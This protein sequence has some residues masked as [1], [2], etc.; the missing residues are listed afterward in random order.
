MKGAIISLFVLCALILVVIINGVFVTTTVK[1]IETDIQSISLEEYG[2]EDALL[3]VERAKEI[4]KSKSTLLCLSLK[5]KELFEIEG[6]LNELAACAKANTEEEFGIAK[7]RLI[8]T[9]AQIRQLH[10]IG[11][12]SIF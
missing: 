1:S 7:S 8:S 12:N 9:L 4:Y 5:D 11:L 2:W 10:S 6:Y 3:M